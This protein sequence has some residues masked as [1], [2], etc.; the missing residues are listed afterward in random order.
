MHCRMHE[1][2]NLYVADNLAQR[3]GARIPAARVP[4]SAV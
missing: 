4:A 1:V 3:L 2:D